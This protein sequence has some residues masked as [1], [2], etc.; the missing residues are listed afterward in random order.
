M[1]CTQLYS[2]N[3]DHLF[4]HYFRKGLPQEK[5]KITYSERFVQ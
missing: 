1:R 3:F 4:D 2:E 5:S